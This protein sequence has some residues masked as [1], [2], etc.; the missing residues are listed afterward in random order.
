MDVLGNNDIDDVRWLCSLTDSE[1]DLLMGLK[2]MMNMR[3]KQIGHEY[4][5]KKFDLKMLRAL[6]FIFM[7][8]L[9]GLLKDVPAAADFHCNLLKESPSDSFSSM[10]VE[11]LYPYIHSDQKKRIADMFLQDMPP[12]RRSKSVKRD[13]SN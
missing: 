3:A 13:S 10:T 11:D 7:E 5:A 8:H 4:L 9:K 12:S 2:T 1:L 6:S